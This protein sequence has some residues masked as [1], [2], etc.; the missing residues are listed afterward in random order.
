M[1]DSLYVD[2]MVFSTSTL[3]CA[4]G[5]YEKARERMMSGGFR[6]RKWVTNNQELAERIKCREE[7][8]ERNCDPEKQFEESYAKATLGF[9]GEPSMHKVLGLDWNFDNDTVLFDFRPTL[10]KAKAM[11]Q[12]KREVLSLMAGVFDPLGLISPV[13]FSMKVLF[14]ELCKENVGWDDEPKGPLKLRWKELGQ[15][16]LY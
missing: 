11:K 4:Y 9:T 6:L 16:R 1:I 5:M 2:D 10:K 7:S 15:S 8:R 12:T 13:Q 3:E 14:Q